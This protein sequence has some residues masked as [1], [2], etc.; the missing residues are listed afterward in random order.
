MLPPS[1]PRLTDGHITLRAFENRDADLVR[2]VA[3][4]PLIPLITTV[5]TSGSAV[6]VRAY[7]ERQHD[8]LRTGAGYS[9]AIA[10]EHDEAMGNIGLWLTA[11][12][13]GRASTGYWLAP[14]FRR[15]GHGARALRLLSD[16]AMTLTDIARLELYVEPWNVGSWRCAEAC[17]FEREGLLRSWQQVGDERKNMFMYSRIRDAEHGERSGAAQR[18]P[19]SVSDVGVHTTRSSSAKA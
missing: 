4:D 10:D 5:P 8:R 16:W 11:L 9:F 15:R 2:S 1:L 18:Q 17:G 14:R 12:D 13:Q 6:D 3:G 7:I 19:A